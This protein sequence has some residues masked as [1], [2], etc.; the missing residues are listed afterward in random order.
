MIEAS[1]NRISL[2]GE[3]DLARKEELI[4]L[5]AG[6]RSGQPATID[7]SRCTY[8]DSTV[9]AALGLLKRT[10][11]DVPIT[12]IAPQSQTKRLLKITG[13]DKL[14]RIVDGK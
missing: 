2:E 9:L 13:Y 7:L 5:L 6:L 1:R 12:L 3:W 11:E 10:F 14:F 4:A 8:A